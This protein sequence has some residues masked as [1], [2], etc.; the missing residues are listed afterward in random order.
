MKQLRQGMQ[1][2]EKLYTGTYHELEKKRRR[3]ISAHIVKSNMNNLKIKA[4]GQE[5]SE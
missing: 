4:T 5:K 1:N 2:V 3:R